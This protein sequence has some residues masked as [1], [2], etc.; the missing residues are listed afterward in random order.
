VGGQRDRGAD[1]ANQCSARSLVAFVSR[2]HRLAMRQTV[3]GFT[4]E[5]AEQ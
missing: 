3:S 5:A 2:C 1:R 4:T